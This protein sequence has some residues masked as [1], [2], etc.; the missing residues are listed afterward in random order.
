MKTSSNSLVLIARTGAILLACCG[1]AAT[2]QEAEGSGFRI[3]VTGGTLGIGPEAG[4]RFSETLG[5]RTNA[6]FL[7]INATADSDD[8]EFDGNLRLRSAGLMLDIHPFGGGFRISPGFRLNGNRARAVALPNAGQTYEIDGN[9]YTA[10]EIGTLTAE[11]DLKKVA[12]S[13]TL[14]YGGGVGR[15]VVLGIEAGALFQG[16]VGIKP[17]VVTGV[18]ANPASSPDCATLAADLESER[19]S[20]EDDISSYKVYPILQLSLSYRF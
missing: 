1:T 11:T 14:G 13:L 20:V 6:T 5:V 16:A 19:L 18:C 15:G 3:G 4:F 9:V 17:L 8:L 12:P 7:S 2:A 10:D